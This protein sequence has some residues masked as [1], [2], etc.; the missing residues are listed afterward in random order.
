MFHLGGVVWLTLFEDTTS[1]HFFK[2]TSL[3]L[4]FRKKQPIYPY[5]III[6]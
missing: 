6:I 2:F 5:T 1:F 3:P 4:H